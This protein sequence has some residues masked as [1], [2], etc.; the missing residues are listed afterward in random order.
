[1]DFFLGKGMI[2]GFFLGVF[3]GVVFVKGVCFGVLEISVDLNLV[4]FEGFRLP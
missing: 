3:F 1:M 4:K 2:L